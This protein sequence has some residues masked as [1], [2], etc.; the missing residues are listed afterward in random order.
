MVWNASTLIPLIAAILYG[1]VFIF[2]VRARPL[3]QDRRAFLFYLLAMMLWDIGSF[4]VHS[5]LGNTLTYFRLMTTAGIVG[6]FNLITFIQR[7]LGRKHAWMEWAYLLIAV[8]ALLA[9][10]SPMAFPS[11]GIEEGELKYEFGPLIYIF[12]PPIYILFFLSIRA[13]RQALVQT[14]SPQQRIRYRYLLIGLVIVLIGSFVNFTPLGRYPIDVALNGVNALLIAYAIIRHELLDIQVVIRKGLAYTTLILALGLTYLVPILVVEIATIQLTSGFNII[15]VLIALG[16]S[17]VIAGTVH[18]FYEDIRDRI[19]RAYF[20]EHYD[21]YKM[22]QE[23]A[24]KM[25]STMDLDIMTSILMK[26]LG[27]TLHIGTIAIMLRESAS[28]NFAPTATRGFAPDTFNLFW[29]ENH[30]ICRWLRQE[31]RPLKKEQLDILPTLSGV[32]KE[33][34]DQLEK[35][36]IKIFIPLRS[37]GDLVGIFLLGAKQSGEEYSSDDQNLLNT[38]ASHVAVALENARLFKETNTRLAEQIALLEIGNGLA[39]ASDLDDILQLVVKHAC[40]ADTPSAKATIHLIDHE[41]QRLLPRAVSQSSGE[42]A[43]AVGFDPKQGI[44]GRAVQE[45]SLI[46]VPD[47]HKAPDFVNTREDFNSLVVVPLIIEDLP[48]GTLSVTSPHIDAFDEDT[49]RQLTSLANQ[50]AIAL[51]KAQ[52][53]EHLRK[54]NAEL[55]K[56]SKELEASI[57]ELKS[58]QRQLIQASKLASM[59]TLTAGIAHEINNPLAGIKL[60]AQNTKRAYISGKLKPEKMVETLEK[61]SNLVDKAAKIIEHLRTFSRQATGHMEL[62]RVNQ[63]VEDSLSMLS[64]QLKLQNIEIIVQLDENLPQVRGDTNQ[65]EQVVLNLITN[66]RDSLDTAEKKRISLRTYQDN[67]SVVIEVVDSGSG[68]QP[69]IIE[70]VFDPFFTTKPVDKGTGLGLS[71]SH[72]IVELHG[73]EIEVESTPNKGST[74]RVKLPA[75]ENGLGND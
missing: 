60:F 43:Q 54:S 17:V 37:K 1:V 55:E 29:V 52:I 38:L 25:A 28:S 23:L 61:I 74:F 15:S 57:E 39:H 26:R 63:A 72:G 53:T 73:G 30:P 19:D 71:I 35:L 11:A 51:R 70:N 9:L 16:M 40:P 58:T 36:G 69:D 24:E 12:A 33:D 22:V 49:I 34:L 66:A 44:A 56:R 8:F 50:A 6:I 62:M 3:T 47:V 4:M 46:Y 75:V 41:T 65:I 7:V 42:P 67:G 64:E 68:I 48:E 59:G 18:W 10:F 5:G 31:G 27:E 14:E 13:L 45:K 20:R 32:W 21:A 2:V